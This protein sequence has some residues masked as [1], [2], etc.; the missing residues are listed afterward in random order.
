MAWPA[1]ESPWYRLAPAARSGANRSRPPSSF[2][3]CL[4]SP[5][6]GRRTR[7]IALPASGGSDR[8]DAR[9][10][11]ARQRGTVYNSLPTH[12]GR[13]VTGKMIDRLDSVAFDEAKSCLRARKDMLIWRLAQYDSVS[14]MCSRSRRNCARQP[15]SEAAFRRPRHLVEQAT[16]GVRLSVAPATCPTRVPRQCG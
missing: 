5:T 12:R 14:E 1:P 7:P 3:C 10:K 15:S 6:Y 9:C 2:G 13:H 11:Q 4:V 8:V 16:G